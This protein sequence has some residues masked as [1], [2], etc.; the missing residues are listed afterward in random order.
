MTK[1]IEFFSSVP[2]VA[3]TFPI[4]PARQVLPGWIHQARADYLKQKDK[5]ELHIFKCPGIF[6]MFGT[7]N[8]TILIFSSFFIMCCYLI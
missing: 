2:G 1:K 6:E 7:A 3:E 5:R 4:V 8:L